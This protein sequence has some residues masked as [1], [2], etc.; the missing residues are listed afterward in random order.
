MVYFLVELYKNS[1]ALEVCLCNLPFSLN[2][3]FL[4]LIHCELYM[5]PLLVLT[6]VYDLLV[7]LSCNLVLPLPNNE[8]LGC[9]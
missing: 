1:V 4:K 7:W 9:F 6:A 2:V 3:R 8:C 5:C